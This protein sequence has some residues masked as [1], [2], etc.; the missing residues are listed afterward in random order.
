MEIGKEFEYAH[1]RRLLCVYW[2]IDHHGYP[3]HRQE[4]CLRLADIT[5]PPSRWRQMKRLAWREKY[6]RDSRL[7]KQICES[8]RWSTRNGGHAISTIA[9]EAILLLNRLC[10]TRRLLG[11]KRT[12]GEI[13]ENLLLTL[14]DI[15]PIDDFCLRE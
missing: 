2:F 6:Q 15:S 1:Y 10:D 8:E 13:S 12:C 5:P 11:E 7:T 3:L 9:F 4:Q 14:I